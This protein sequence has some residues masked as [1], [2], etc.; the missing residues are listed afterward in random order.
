[1][2]AWVSV[3][4]K[5]AGNILICVGIILFLVGVAKRSATVVPETVIRQEP[6]PQMKGTNLN[7]PSV[8]PRDEIKTLPPVNIKLTHL[9]ISNEDSHLCSKP[10]DAYY[11]QIGRLFENA[12]GYPPKF[13]FDTLHEDSTVNWADGFKGI[14]PVCFIVDDEGNVKDIRFPQPPE[15]VLQAQIR[16]RILGWRFQPGYLMYMSTDS[17]ER[18]AVKIQLAYDFG[19]Q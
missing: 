4:F 1:M 6:Q 2:A 14:V 10:D 3:W 15:E 19:F 17:N 9:S 12:R 11:G 16:R 5:R 13:L 8:R 18:K 7:L